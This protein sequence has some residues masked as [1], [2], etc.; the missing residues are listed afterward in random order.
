MGSY[1][2]RF[3]QCE[4]ACRYCG[5]RFP[6]HEIP[7]DRWQAQKGQR[8]SEEWYVFLV[9]CFDNLREFFW[10][11]RICGARAVDDMKAETGPWDWET[12]GF[13][14]TNMEL[15]RGR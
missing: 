11:C 2:W 3:N 15:G 9:N 7:F 13:T 14:E 5:R 4:S 1:W 6:F 10:V 8:V 12:R